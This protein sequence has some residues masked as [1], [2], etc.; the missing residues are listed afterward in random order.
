MR[1]TCNAAQVYVV[2]G[3]DSHYGFVS[4]NVF[5]FFHTAKIAF[6]C[7]FCSL[8]RIRITN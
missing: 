3:F 6:F 8:W 4:G 7:Y 1:Y 2:T 5:D